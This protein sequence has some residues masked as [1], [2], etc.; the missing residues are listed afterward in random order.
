MYTWMH[1]G[2]QRTSTLTH[3]IV[4]LN[5]C[6]DLLLNSAVFAQM[7]APDPGTPIL[8]TV[9]TL[10]DLVRAGKVRYVGCCNMPGWHMQKL[11]DTTHYLGLNPFVALQVSALHAHS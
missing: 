10:D 9:R 2:T 11:V 6:L 3:P 8:E 1:I 7:H 5:F 4:H